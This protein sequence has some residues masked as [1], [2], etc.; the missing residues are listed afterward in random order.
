MATQKKCID[1]NLTANAKLAG[2][3]KKGNYK[4]LRY[5]RLVGTPRKPGNAALP[6]NPA[7]LFFRTP[8]PKVEK[9]PEKVIKFDSAVVFSY[10]NA[11]IG[12]LL[13]AMF[14]WGKDVKYRTVYRDYIV[15]SE[16]RY[17][18]NDDRQ[19]ARTLKYIALPPGRYRQ[20][21]EPETGY[22][23][24]QSWYKFNA[25]PLK[26]PA[27]RWNAITDELKN[28]FLNYTD[29]WKGFPMNPFD[30]MNTNYVQNILRQVQQLT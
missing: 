12:K 1:P 30:E 4:T 20:A 8:K 5:Y 27:A 17:T 16:S 18:Y 14:P 10:A 29:G 24:F 3:E 11:L 22:K 9:L 28:N 21:L 19:L 15:V 7:N 2:G 23:A 6:A 26:D 13:T 25:L